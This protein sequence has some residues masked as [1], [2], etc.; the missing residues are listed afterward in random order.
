MLAERMLVSVPKLIGSSACFE[1][2]D[3]RGKLLVPAFESLESP[4]E[5]GV[6]EFDQS[7]RFLE[8]APENVPPA[9]LSGPSHLRT[10][11]P[12]E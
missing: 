2:V 7:P 5:L 3:P 10:T 1:V 11:R 4:I 6:G 8:L 12:P 9:R